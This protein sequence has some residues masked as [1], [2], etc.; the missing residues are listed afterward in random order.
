MKMTI[1]LNLDELKK[2][3]AKHFN[4]VDH[5]I[6]SYDIK[7]IGAGGHKVEELTVYVDTD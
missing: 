2:I 1:K 5:E 6:A 7:E 3:I 4:S